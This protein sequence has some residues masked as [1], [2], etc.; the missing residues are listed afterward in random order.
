MFINLDNFLIQFQKQYFA[1]RYISHNPKNKTKSVGKILKTIIS[2][3]LQNKHSM[4]G[5]KH[6]G[7]NNARFDTNVNIIN[8]IYQAYEYASTVLNRL[9]PSDVPCNEEI[10]TAIEGTLKHAEK[11]ELKKENF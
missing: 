2:D 10:D 9:K 8:V 6:K 5:I 3:E 7:F 4:K 1:K 11:S